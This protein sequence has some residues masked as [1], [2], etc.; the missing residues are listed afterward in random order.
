MPSNRRRF[1]AALAGTGTLALAGCS[2]E[3]STTTTGPV[4]TTTGLP[5]ETTTVVSPTDTTTVPGPTP[6]TTTTSTV[7]IDALRTLSEQYVSDL[8]DEQYQRLIDEYDYTE[9]VAAQLDATGLE[10]FWT[11]QIAG[12]GTFT[13]VA[14]IEYT[15]Q[16]GFHVFVVTAQFSSGQQAVRLVYDDSGAIAGLQFPQTQQ[17]WSAPAYADREAFTETDLAIETPEGCTLGGTLTL[18]AGEESVPAVVLVHGSGPSDRDATI[19]PNKPFKDLAWG[20]ASR[21]V[22]VYRYEKRTAACQVDGTTLTLDQETTDDALTALQRVG[23]HDRVDS[24]FVAGHSLG[25]MVTP[26]IASRADSLAGAIMLAA[27]ARDL[28][29]LILDQ[30]RYLA[31]LDGTITDD[32]SQQIEAVEQAVERIRTLD[33]DEGETVLGAGRP[34]WASLQDY[35]QVETAQ[36]L[37]LPRL[38]LQGGRD[39]QVTVEDD[40]QV[41]RDALGGESSVAFRQYSQLN[42]LFMPGAGAASPEEYYRPGNVDV[43]VVEDVA[44]WVLDGSL[45]ENR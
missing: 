11:R 4:E 42:H 8:G 22:A 7:D 6:T 3:Q 26:R 21:G 5:A 12:L 20:L 2:D 44:N 40:L 14:G 39:Y 27:P 16:Q 23:G 19:G 29:T 28:S 32:E 35:E 10:S 34:Y 37:S 33:I 36:Q 38:F 13:D 30:T 45:T 31:D 18:P 17:E 1:L 9:Q 15:T 25:G 43:A 24:V 41:W